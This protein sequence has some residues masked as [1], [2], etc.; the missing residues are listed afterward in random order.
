MVEIQKDE[1]KR[2]NVSGGFLADSALLLAVRKD[3]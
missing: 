1:D 3:G 2:Q